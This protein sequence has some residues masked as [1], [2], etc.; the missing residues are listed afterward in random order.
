MNS[1]LVLGMDRSE[2]PRFLHIAAF[3]ITCIAGPIAACAQDQPANPPAESPAASPSVPD[4]LPKLKEMKTPTAEELLTQKPHDWIVLN[5]DDV[6]VVE[7]LSPRPRTLE[8][9]QQQISETLEAR[10]K[11]LGEK[12]EQLDRELETLNSFVVILGQG[13][14][15]LE[16]KLPVRLVK[17]IIHHEDLCM[18]RVEALLNEKQLDQAFELLSR[19]ERDQPDWDGARQAGLKLLLMNAQQQLEENQPEAALVLLNELLVRDRGNPAVSGLMGDATRQLVEGALKEGQLARAQYFLDSLRRRFSDHPVY[20]EYAETLSRQASSQMEQATQASQNGDLRASLLLAEQAVSTWPPTAELKG[21]YGKLARRYQRL[22]VGVT[23][24]PGECVAYPLPSPA[25]LR[26]QQLT[27]LSLFEVSRVRDGTAYYRTRFFDEWEP[28]DLGR[29]LHFQLRRFRQPSEMQ[30]LVTAQE[31]VAPILQRLDPANPVYDER[32]AAFIESADIKSPTEFTLIWKRVPPRV[33]PLLADLSLIV[34]DPTTSS[35]LLLA[36]PGGFRLVNQTDRLCEYVRV[37]PE[38]TGLSKYH[39]AEVVEHR[40]DSAAKVVSGLRQGEV[41]MASGLPDIEV[42]TLQEDAEFNRSFFIQPGL[43]PVT[44]VLQFNPASAPMRVSELRKGL[45]YAVNGE[46]I[47]KEIVLRDPRARHGRLVTTPF[48]SKNPA[49]NPTVVPRRF[50]LSNAF[51]LTVAAR[52]KLKGSIPPLTMVVAPG[53][54]ATQ[55]AQEIARTW[56]RLGLEIQVVLANEPAPP[57]WDILYRTLEMTEPVLEMWPFLAFSEHA[58]IDS[59]KAYPDWIKQEL[60]QVDRTGD[61]TRAVDALQLLHKH[62]YDD[63]AFVPL[64]EVDQFFI[65]RKNIQG[66]PERFIRCYDDIDRWS[67]EP[68]YRE[69]LQ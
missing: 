21:P 46:Q 62:L 61:Q 5:N 56:R 24:L 34:P 15:R 59:L 9:R 7:P 40:Y 57:A 58:T 54:V 23:D 65:L 60:V 2:V 66:F 38:P 29:E 32:L 44:H 16:F 10:G 1:L 45:A 50:D 33:E 69:T 41:S 13:E 67:L 27:Q 47:L 43:I 37:I 3:M 39:V 18:K 52:Q 64:W 19:V 36:D 53:E 22:H 48:S 25:D 49:R 31:I 11:V 35:P 63:G 68:W 6:L 4:Q 55:A 14:T 51:A 28:R 26:K 42:R 30:G 8:Q 17:Q 12:R 20:R